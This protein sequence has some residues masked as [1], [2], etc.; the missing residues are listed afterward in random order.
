MSV[1]K[2]EAPSHSYEVLI[3]EFTLDHVGD[4]CRSISGGDA[5]CVVSDSNVAPLYLDRAKTSLEAAGYRVETFVFPAGEQSKT[6]STYAQALSA[7]AN[8]GL[9]RSSLVVALGGGV[10]GDLAGFAAATYM[11]GIRCVQV[12]TSLLACVDSSVG[13]K[14]AVDLPEGKNLVGAFF[15]P[16]AVL[17]DT[18]LLATLP[19]HFFIDGCG[20]VLKYGVIFDSDLFAEL[21]SC[22]AS[23]MRLGEVIARCVQLKRDVVQADEKEAGQRQLL[24]FGHTLGHAIEK[25]SGFTVT[26]G[27]AVA[28]GM[29]LVAKASAKR[30]WLSAQDAQRIERAVRA[31]GLLADTNESAQAIYDAA[32]ADKKRRGSTMNVVVASEIG[33]ARIESLKLDDFRT[34]VGQA[35]A[36]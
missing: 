16:D 35:L 26:H 7:F 12:P 6:L 32:L 31:W 24:N 29:V 9:T 13:G 14:T 34:F 8:A 36:R 10:V 4:L 33:K 25:L 5:C 30:G 18:S 27:F 21:E 15:Q 19:E 23:D 3:D 28:C 17:V 20:E 11:R 1:V 22:S 2:V